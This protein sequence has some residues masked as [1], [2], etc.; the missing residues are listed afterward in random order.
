MEPP[1]RHEGGIRFGTYP[2]SSKLLHPVAER[3]QKI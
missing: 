2:V 3:L 1:I